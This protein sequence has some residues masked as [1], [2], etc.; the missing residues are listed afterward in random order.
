MLHAECFH[1]KG[2]SVDNRTI[3]GEDTHCGTAIKFGR[4]AATPAAQLR[5]VPADHWDAQKNCLR[6]SRKCWFSAPANLPNRRLEPA[7]MSNSDLRFL[8][9]VTIRYERSGRMNA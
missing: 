8:D 4:S 5:P 6:R 7:E 2:R 3:F 1:S 9:N